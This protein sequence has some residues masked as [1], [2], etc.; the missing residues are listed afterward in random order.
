MSR[1]NP[2]ATIAFEEQLVPSANR[3]EIAKTNQRVASDSNITNSFLKLDVKILKHHKL[4]NLISL[5]TIISII[6]LQQ[7]LTTIT[8]NSSNNTFQFKL[9]SQQLTLNAD[10]LHIILQMPPPITSKPFTKPPTKNALLAFIKTLG[11]DEDPKET[12]TT[13]PHFVAT[14]LH[15]PRRAILSV[16][17]ICL[18]DMKSEEQDYPIS[19]LINTIKGEIKFG[20]EIPDT[21]INDAIKE[22]AGYKYYK[23]KKNENGKDNAEEEPEEKHV[24]LVRR[25]KGKWYMCIGNQEVNVSRKP[26]KV[27][28][29][30]KQ[31]T[32]TVADN[33]VEQETLKIEKQVE[34]DVDEGYA[35]ERGLKLKGVSTEDLA[36]QSLIALRKGSKESKVSMYEMK[37]KQV[38]VKDATEDSDMDISGNDSKKGDDDA[39]GFGVFVLRRLG[40]IFTS[41]Y[42]AVQKLKKALGWSFNSAWLTI[43]S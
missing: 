19:K 23:I 31:R 40:S 37:C 34:K 2:Q 41:M 17:N 14:R 10:V 20:M 36:V 1:A 8:H 18:T 21:M 38:E 35:V 3:L 5:D 15:E 30:R 42:A 6:Y 32:I 16:L 43:P 25:G 4:Y 22:S 39:T 27:V 24:T 7:F 12:M 13:I 26:K 29:P 9:D 33:I 28:V 11:Y